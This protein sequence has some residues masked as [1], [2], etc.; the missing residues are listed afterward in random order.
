MATSGFPK[1]TA[2]LRGETGAVDGLAYRLRSASEALVVVFSQVRVPAG[3]FGL[4]RLFAATTHSLLFLNEPVNGWYRNRE[5]VLDRLIGEAATVVKA[6][7]LIFYGSSMG[8]FGAA[9]TAALA[10]DL[11]AAS[12]GL[13]STTRCRVA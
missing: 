9:A 13:A 12:L 8:A 2:S 4:E 6:K 5:A 10:S 7:R 1:V 11:R 3:K